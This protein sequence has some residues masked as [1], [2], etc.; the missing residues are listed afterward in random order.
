M[1]THSKE[2]W[3]IRDDSLVIYS[4]AVG[5]VYVY[6]IAD[7]GA[8][9]TDF[10]QDVIAANARRIVACIN[11]C[12]GIDTFMLEAHSNLIDAEIA[13]VD[14]LKHQR[15]LL[16]A[17]IGDAAVAVGIAAAGVPMDGP[18]L[19][20]LAEDIRDDNLRL[21][22]QRDELLSA[23]ESYG[24]PFDNEKLARAEFGDG[25]VD[26]EMNRRAVIALARGE[27]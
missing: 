22:S 20:M 25:A 8:T 9:A 24:L 21:T 3:A 16:A 12:E 11:V 15:D 26:R 13:T 19:L 14:N 2:P 18:T 10:P 23:L 27:A 5:D 4:E 7:L 17:A 6:E 1:S